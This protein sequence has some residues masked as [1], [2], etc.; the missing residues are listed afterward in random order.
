MTTKEEYTDFEFYTD[1]MSSLFQT[2]FSMQEH[3]E[4]LSPNE[5]RQNFQ[6]HVENIL[7]RYKG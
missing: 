6:K 1:D 5:V 7:K 2:L 3:V 4:L